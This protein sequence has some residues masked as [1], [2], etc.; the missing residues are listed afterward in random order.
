MVG[1]KE[2]DVDRLTRNLQAQTAFLCQASRRYE[3]LGY[4]RR[5]AILRAIADWKAKQ[6]K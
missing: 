5:D 3:S 1:H 2:S 6:R 4:S